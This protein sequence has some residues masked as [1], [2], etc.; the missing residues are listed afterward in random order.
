MSARHA[1]LSLIGAATFYYAAGES[2]R[3][4]VDLD[5][6]YGE[7]AR[8]WRRREFSTFVLGGLLPDA[9]DAPDDPD[10]EEPG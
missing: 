7:D 10:E 8:A 6:L 2:S 3:G 9:P 4:I 1:L 5:D